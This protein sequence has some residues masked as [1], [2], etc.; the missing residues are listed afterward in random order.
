MIPQAANN[1]KIEP[2]L[3]KFKK[4]TEKYLKNL[5]DPNCLID[6]LNNLCGGCNYNLK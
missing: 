2:K 3:Q 6:P 1:N 5:S 4:Y